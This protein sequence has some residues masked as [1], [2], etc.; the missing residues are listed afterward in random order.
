MN[1]TPKI[2]IDTYLWAIRMYKSRSL[3]GEAIRGGKVKLNAIPVKASHIVKAGEIYTLSNAKNSKTIEVI[4]LIEKR[5]SYDTVK[6]CYIDHS[7]VVDKEEKQQKAFFIMNL[8]H[9]KG[10]GRPTKRNR[11]NLGKYGAWF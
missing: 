6:K 2:R 11:R 10:S 4:E 9:E 5:G 3:A 1:E 7:P 8:K